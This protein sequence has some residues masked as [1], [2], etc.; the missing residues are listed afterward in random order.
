MTLESLYNT[1][2]K[3]FIFKLYPYVHNYEIAEDLVQEA[4]LRALSN[5]SQYDEKKGALKGWFTKILFSCLWNYKRQNKKQPIT[6]DIDSVSEEEL[7]SYAEGE[8]VREYLQ[9]IANPKHRKALISHLL[10]GH[11]YSETAA[12][13]SLEEANVRKILSRFREKEGA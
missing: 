8:G 6:Y 12:V 4:F 10:L 7:M 3:T 9:S 1:H 2:R 11:T 13:A 5:L